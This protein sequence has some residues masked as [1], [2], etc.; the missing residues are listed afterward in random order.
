MAVNPFGD[1]E[2]DINLHQLLRTHLNVK[3]LLLINRDGHEPDFH[4]KIY[5]A[6]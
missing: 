5:D 3:I 2:T 4:I 1:D 6:G